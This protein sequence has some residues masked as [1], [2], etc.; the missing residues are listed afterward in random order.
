MKKLNS[1][2]LP[3]LRLHDKSTNQTYLRTELFSNIVY[4]PPIFNRQT[5]HNKSIQPYGLDT[6]ADDKGK[7]FLI[8][9]S[10]GDKWT[11]NDFP[12]CIFT[13]KYRNSTFLVYNLRYDAGSL[14]QNLDRSSLS[15]L[16]ITGFCE[17]K[18][19]RYK[20][21]NNKFLS[22]AR[23]KNNISIYDLYGFFLTSLDNACK[24]FL[25]RGK[26]DIETKTFTKSFITDNYDRI[27]E[28]CIEDA[29]LVRD[30]GR[31]LIKYF[32]DFGV[33]PRK[34]YSTAYVSWTYF[35]THCP[36][37]HVKKYWNENRLLLQYACASYSGGKF[38][39]TRKGPDM[40]YEYDI[41]SAY[42][43]EIANLIDIREGR[44][45][46]N[47]KYDSN[48][49]YSFLDVS[50]KIP[51]NLANPTA[52][53]NH[54][55]CTF[56]VG[57]IRRIITKSEYEY[58]VKNNCDITIN[59]AYHI[60]VKNITYPYREEIYR[61]MELKSLYK[62]EKEEF[63]YHL[64][65][66]LLNSLYGKMAQLIKTK[67]VYKAGAAWNPIYSSVITANCRIRVSEMQRLYNSIVAVHTDSII[68]TKPLD[69]KTGSG[70]GEWEK[71]KEGEGIILGTGIYQIGEKSRFRGFPTKMP[72]ID[73]IPSSGKTMSIKRI[74]P[75]S[76]RETVFRNQ[77]L[78]LI[79]RFLE[80]EKELKL[81]FDRK[82]LWLD[83]YTNYKQVRERT[84]ESLPLVLVDYSE[85][86]SAE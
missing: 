85:S 7:C 72:L 32:E 43:Y 67:Q 68:S 81:N 64:V 70:L 5:I 35:R 80:T 52:I 12:S 17:Y 13:R 65:K 46:R 14:L 15:E 26:I 71:S 24:Q 22:I 36:Y 79:N 34:L 39:V 42:P 28:Y 44:V 69:I 29:R 86:M 49:V 48:S 21:I 1:L 66:I 55:V 63:K 3:V 4:N 19:F 33:Y 37:I 77:S 59:D 78:R 82:R 2:S 74:A 50:L 84:V 60:H 38:E 25:G 8:C 54:N 41:V 53:K 62:V 11:L 76:W 58:F 23:G 10:E 83:D 51:F 9:S 16:R 6:E 56:P 31:K 47:K 61:L 20:V 30:L 18:G 57:L 27:A 75:Q 45:I 40:Y 73:L